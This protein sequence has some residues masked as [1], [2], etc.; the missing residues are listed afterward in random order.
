MGKASELTREQAQV[1]W[2]QLKRE[3]RTLP[4][5]VE[6]CATNRARSFLDDAELDLHVITVG[7][8]VRRDREVD[9]T[10]VLDNYGDLLAHARN[11]LHSFLREGLSVPQE[12]EQTALSLY[13]QANAVLQSRNPFFRP[14]RLI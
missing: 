7:R 8:T 5:D 6:A 3:A 10:T 11:A 12:V 4:R 9:D 14:L 13:A 2:A 1:L